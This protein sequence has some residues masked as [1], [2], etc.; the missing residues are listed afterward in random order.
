MPVFA[1]H[2]LAHA[3]HD[4]VLGFDEPRILS[5]YEKAKAGGTYEKVERRDAQGRVSTGR[6]YAMT[7]HKEY[8]AETA[9][10]FFGTND[11]F[12]YVREELGRHDPEMFALLQTL[13]TG[14]AEPGEATRR[15]AP[16][17]ELPPVNF[18]HPPRDYETH[19]AR[20][21]T[22][23]VEKQLA[24]EAPEL[25]RRAL[26]RLDRT[27]GEAIVVLPESA[28]PRL[29][30]L[31]L[32][33]M[34]GVASTAGGRDNGLEYFQATAP[35]HY[36][37]LDPRMASSIVIYSAANYVWISRFWA[38]KALVHE[39]AH[40][41]DLEQW[42]EFRRDIYEAWQHAEKLGLYRNVKDD[43]GATLEKAYA[44][45]NHLEYFAEISCAYFV[46]CNYAPFNRAEL[47][48]YDP[49]G[50]A[51]VEKLWGIAAP[52]SADH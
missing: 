3:Y 46:G 32:F 36:P 43:A 37:N 26:R 38:L 8:F 44:A 20:G 21:W 13:W 35:Q 47:K 4:R 42:P 33:L 30:R 24:V 48:A 16:A 25:A 7:D 39:C 23:F 6:A 51:L 9:E 18:N 19:S 22:V 52:V 28:R 41:H 27:L 14:P 34:Y 31:T 45:Q 12:P 29:Q 15:T 50:Y 49:V 10:A 2:E 11:F 40:A 1:L 17:L 5:A